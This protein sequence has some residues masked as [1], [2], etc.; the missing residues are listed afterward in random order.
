MG[1]KPQREVKVQAVDKFVNELKKIQGE[2]K[3]AL[4]KAHDDMNCFAD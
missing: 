4:H 1:F 2:A 3:V